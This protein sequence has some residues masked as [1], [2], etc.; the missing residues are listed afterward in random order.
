MPPGGHIE[1]NESHEQAALREIKEELGFIHGKFIIACQIQPKK[2]DKRARITLQPHLILK[3]E[4]A[5]DHFHLDLIFYAVCHEQE[6]SS[7]EGHMTKW[8]TL[9]EIRREENMIP[10]VRLL[11][12]QGFT[13]QEFETVDFSFF[14]SSSSM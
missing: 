6:I 3:E 5:P 2:I 13:F 7:P 4:I 9:D 8:M 14:D 10:N 1:T 12:I 11:A